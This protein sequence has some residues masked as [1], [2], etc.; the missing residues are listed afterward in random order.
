MMSDEAFVT[1]LDEAYKFN[2]SDYLE[3]M[4]KISVSAMNMRRREMNKSF[5]HL[6]DEEFKQVA[7]NL[8]KTWLTDGKKALAVAIEAA[9]EKFEQEDENE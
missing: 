2:V 8:Y 3:R 4:L 9:I 1:P 7:A 5:I 6:T